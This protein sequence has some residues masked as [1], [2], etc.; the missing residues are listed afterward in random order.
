M[1]DVSSITVTIEPPDT[2]TVLVP[3]RYHLQL[4]LSVPIG[5]HADSVRFKRR[6]GKLA[7]L[8]TVLSDSEAAAAA[9]AAAASAASAATQQ[10]RAKAAAA[11]TGSQQDPLH[12]EPQDAAQHVQ[13]VQQTSRQQ[14][15]A[16]NSSSAHA[17]QQ[18]QQQQQDTPTGSQQQQQQAPGGQQQAVKLDSDLP[19]QLKSIEEMFSRKHSPTLVGCCATVFDTLT[20]TAVRLGLG[21]AQWAEGG[22]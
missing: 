20:V 6:T 12:G 19:P 5:P 15:P 3:D 10:K 1:K 17:P 13:H 21:L 14:Q 7:M 4:H 22:F 9:A 16:G 18:Q 11:E 8:C 2:V